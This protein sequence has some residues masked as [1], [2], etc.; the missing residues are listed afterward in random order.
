MDRP[1]LIN[2]D[3]TAVV[4]FD[5]EAHFFDPETKSQMYY[6]TD[7]NHIY[8]RM[9]KLKANVETFQVFNNFF[10]KDD[11]HCFMQ[12]KKLNNADVKSFE[13][14][15][16]CFAKDH[17]SVWCLGGKFQPS[18]I[19]SFQVCDDGY[20]KNLMHKTFYFSDGRAIDGI[21]QIPSGYAK[22]KYQVY[23]YDH[24]GKV[25]IIKKADSETFIS[26]N[27]GK[28]GKDVRY[29]Y[30]YFHPI[31][32]ADPKTWKLLDLKEGYSCDGKHV[33]RFGFRFEHTDVN[34]LTLFTFTNKEGYIIKFLKDKNGLFDLDGT[35]ITEQ[36]IKEIYA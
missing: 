14:L 5:K 13:A 19:E 6:W 20:N 27:D 34:T 11:Q 21:T 17:Q 4:C 25:K 36:K 8:W 12:D 26:C 35:R 3:L 30:Y 31:K 22:D 29:V 33:F 18:D 28:F 1:Q 10:A 2:I 16:Y 24:A 15:N 7:G 9:I 23:C 32:K